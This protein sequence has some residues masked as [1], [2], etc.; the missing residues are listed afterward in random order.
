M[1]TLPEQREQ[2]LWYL[3][4]LL[5]MGL[6]YVWGGDDSLAGFDCS[7]LVHEVLQSVGLEPHGHDSIAHDIYLKY[8][9][10]PAYDMSRRAGCLVFWFKDGK[11]T[12]VE[13]MINSWQVVGASG[14]GSKTKTLADAIKHNAFI[15]PRPIDYRGSN[16]KVVDPFKE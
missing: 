11:A 8:K 3:N 4:A 6:P 13:M 7:G 1:P 15:K 10:K 2:A 14:G 9:H 5:I 12:H 16:F